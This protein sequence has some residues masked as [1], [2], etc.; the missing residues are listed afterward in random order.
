MT[1]LQFLFIETCSLSCFQ[2]IKDF[3]SFVHDCLPLATEP[4]FKT[5]VFFFFI[6]LGINM[7]LLIVQLTKEQWIASE[8]ATERAEFGFSAADCWSPPSE[9]FHS[10]ELLFSGNNLNLR[11]LLLNIESI[12]CRYL[13]LSATHQRTLLIIYLSIP[14]SYGT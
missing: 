11:R 9:L 12:N 6:Y 4:S 5:I 1:A 13:L 3:H 10:T 14:N 7:I 2:M 8:N